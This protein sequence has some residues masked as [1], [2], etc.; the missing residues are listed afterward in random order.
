MIKKLIPPERLP[1]HG[2]PLG[3]KQRK[4]LE[5]AGAFPRRVQTSARSHAYIESEI[6]A[7]AEACIARRD[8]REAA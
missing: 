3:N 6:I 7:Y 8:G 1:E 5:D 2:I 4:R